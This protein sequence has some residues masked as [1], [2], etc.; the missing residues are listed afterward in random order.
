MKRNWSTSEEALVGEFEGGDD[1]EGHA[2]REGH[3]GGSEGCGGEGAGDFVDV[4]VGGGGLVGVLMGHDAGDGEGEDLGDVSIDCGEAAIFGND[5]VD[6]LGEFGV[7]CADGDDVVGVVGD[8]GGDGAAG[9]VEAFDEGDGGFGGWGVAVEYG[10][11]VEAF[12]DGAGEAAGDELA[13][14]AFDDGEI[15][16]GWGE[17]CRGFWGGVEVVEGVVGTEGRRVLPFLATSLAPMKV[18]R[19]WK[20]WRFVTSIKSAGSFSRRVP[21][22]RL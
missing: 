6:G 22:G 16:R 14:E 7:G 5:E 18:R 10:D 19:I 4:A 17:I 2:K 21:T 15:C 13:V 9:E 8:G 3:E 12:G 11:F 1:E 20:E